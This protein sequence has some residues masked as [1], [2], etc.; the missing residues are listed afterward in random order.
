MQ[1]NQFF[2]KNQICNF[3]TI[4]HFNSYVWQFAEMILT[5]LQASTVLFKADQRSAALDPP[6]LPITRDQILHDELSTLLEEDD[7]YLS[8][9]VSS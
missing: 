1:F 5:P 8:T 7:Y 4:L 6:L 2:S 3:K 9:M